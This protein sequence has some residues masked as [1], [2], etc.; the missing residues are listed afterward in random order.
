MPGT[1]RL[2][3]RVDQ[4]WGARHPRRHPTSVLHIEWVIRRCSNHLPPDVQV[5]REA[6][7][8]EP[9]LYLLPR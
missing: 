5:H 8:L 7:S 6:E 9:L 3:F 1:S 2:T 4:D